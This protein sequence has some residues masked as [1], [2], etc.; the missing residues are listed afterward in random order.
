MRNSYIILINIINIKISLYSPRCKI[1]F[2]C[3]FI[4]NLLNTFGFES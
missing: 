2:S 3:N 1:P 4:I